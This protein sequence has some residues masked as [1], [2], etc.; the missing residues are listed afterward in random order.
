MIW[1]NLCNPRYNEVRG[2]KM[3]EGI[4]DVRRAGMLDTPG[5]MR[6]LRPRELLTEV[7]EVRRGQTGVDFGSG[8]GFFAL[9][10]AEMVGESGRVYAVDNSEVM[11]AHIR[12]KSLP[13]NLETVRADVI[14]T[15]LPDGVADICLLSSILHEVKQ[16]ARLVAEAARLLKPGGRMVIVEFRADVDS[17]GPPRRKRIPRDRIERLFAQAGITF[18][19][20]REWSLSYYAAVGEKR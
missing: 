5:R 19:S 10:M 16:P 9:P 14:A 8:T 3:N 1:L 15:G 11:Q 6:E 18:L 12:E 17:P 13:P 20:Y 4:F 2:I 7:A